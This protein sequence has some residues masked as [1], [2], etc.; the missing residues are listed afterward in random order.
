VADQADDARRSSRE[1]F[2][3]RRELSL[4]RQQPQQRGRLLPDLGEEDLAVQSASLSPVS[5][6]K[7]CASSG[8]GRR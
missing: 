8:R 6:S 5:G 7:T 4:V 3:D 2:R 1:R